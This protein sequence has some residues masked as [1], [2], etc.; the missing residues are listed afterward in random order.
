MINETGNKY[1]RL[2]VISKAKSKV[3]NGGNS[4]LAMWLCACECGTT[5]TVSGHDLRRGNTTSCGCARRENSL[6]AITKHGDCRRGNWA[7]LYRIW[8][9]MNTRCTNPNTAEFS[10]YGGK[11]IRNEFESYEAFKEWAYANGYYDQPEGTPSAEMLSID[12]IDPAKGYS[13]EN[14][15]WISISENSRRR[16]VDYWSK[17][18]GNPS[19]SPEGTRATTTD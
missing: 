13:P 2:T 7:R 10:S 5:V 12:R 9:N 11:G 18:H 15:R 19:G 4:R 17:K 8:A 14:C 1:G 16:N 3:T 6:K